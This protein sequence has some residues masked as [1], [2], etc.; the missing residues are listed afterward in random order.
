MKSTIDWSASL[1]NIFAY[2]L[3]IVSFQRGLSVFQ[4]LS[5]HK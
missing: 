4:S 3:T 1:K 2:K 5:T